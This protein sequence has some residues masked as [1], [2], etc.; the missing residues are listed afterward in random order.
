M[1]DLNNQTVGAIVA[2]NFKTAAVFKKYGIDFCCKG[3]RTIEEACSDKEITSAEIMEEVNA[4]MQ[5]TKQTSNDYNAWPI[6]LLAD[7]V[8][9][10]HHKYVNDNGPQLLAYLEKINKVHG[11]N[12]PELAEIFEIMKLSIGDLAVHM[13]KEELMLFPYIK[14]MAAASNDN[15]TIT[16]PAFGSITNPINAMK[17]DHEQE[18][19][20][21]MRVMELSNNY[22]PPTDACNTYKVAFALLQEFQDDLLTHIHLE[23]NILF[24]KAIALEQTIFD[25]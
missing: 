3:G 13:K 4:A 25:K 8:Q 6:D 17:A 9:K 18:G 7:Y 15:A 23:N 19:E 22:T 1:E 14:K 10:I 12:H 24:P 20:R 21:L 5:S 2:K 16:P 11:S